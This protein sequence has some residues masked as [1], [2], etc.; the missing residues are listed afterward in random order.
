MLVRSLNFWEGPDVERPGYKIL[1]SWSG[2]DGLML[3]IDHDHDDP[4]TTTE[5]RDLIA[6]LTGI[7]E[8]HS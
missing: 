1:P 5:V 4:Y 7:L 3:F 6:T 8:Q 2:E